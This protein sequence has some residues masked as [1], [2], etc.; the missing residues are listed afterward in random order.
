M[1]K[2]LIIAIIVLLAVAVIAASTFLII[3]ARATAPGAHSEDDNR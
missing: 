2:G 3:R 1:L